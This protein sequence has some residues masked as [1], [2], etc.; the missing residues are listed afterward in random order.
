MSLV[1]AQADNKKQVSGADKDKSPVGEQSNALSMSSQNQN[2]GM[3]DV[4]SDSGQVSNGFITNSAPAPETPTKSWSIRGLISSVPRSFAR[5]LPGW[6]ASSNPPTAPGE[7]GTP[8]QIVSTDDLHVS[9]TPVPS[10]E[11]IGRTADNRQAI[12]NNN[13]AASIAEQK[14]DANAERNTV[15]RQD[16]S[17]SELTYSLFP[18]PL[19]R[20]RFFDDIS[21]PKANARTSSVDKRSRPSAEQPATTSKPTDSPRENGSATPNGEN[22]SQK[23]KRS[24]SPEVIPNPP[25]SSYGM[26]L[27][28][29]TYSSDESDT[30]PEGDSS[31]IERARTETGPSKKVRFNPRPNNSPSKLRTK[32]RATDPYRGQE[33]IGLDDHAAEGDVSTAKSAP[34]GVEKPARQRPG[35]VFIAQGSSTVNYGAEDS[36][37]QE[38]GSQ[39]KAFAGNAAPN[40]NTSTGD[41]EEQKK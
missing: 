21:K 23:R 4:S 24:P 38:S 36:K 6:N 19:D 41:K 30:E 3:M 10:S 28:F 17:P 20:S 32:P 11:R 16:I 25:G 33:F 8:T 22:G 9:E 2:S 7:C 18:P 37:G 39:L 34:S 5:I 12:N 27:R 31:T 13:N 1:A 15:N 29:F 14:S 26:D 35:F 40:V